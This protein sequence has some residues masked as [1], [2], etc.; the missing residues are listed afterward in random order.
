MTPNTPNERRTDA[1]N[2]GARRY[3]FI[4]TCIFAFYF[5]Q[6]FVNL[7]FV[8]FVQL[9]LTRA[10]GVYMNDREKARAARAP[11]APFATPPQPL[12]PT[13]LTAIRKTRTASRRAGAAQAH[14]ASS[15]LQ[16]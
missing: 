8:T 12:T 3:F 7:V 1:Q 6:M 9:Q 5:T 4:T 10:D 13:P 14:R 2:H 15:R 16:T 11:R